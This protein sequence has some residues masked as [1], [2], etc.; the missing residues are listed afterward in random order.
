M[1]NGGKYKI[2]TVCGATGFPPALLRAWENRHGILRPERGAGGHRLYSDDDL[3]V[4]RRI[5]ELRESGRSIS[6][7]SR[8]GRA[9][10]LSDA[11][12][13]A[14]TPRASTQRAENEVIAGSQIERWKETIISSVKALD[15]MKI[16]RELDAAFSC[17]SPEAALQGLLEPLAIEIGNRW[18]HEEIS[19]A[20]EH[21]A[22]AVFVRRIQKILDAETVRDPM[23]PACICA[24]F[25]G[26]QHGIGILMVE[27]FLSRMGFR[28]T[29]LG[30]GLPFEDLE[31]CFDFLYAKAVFLS[32][33]RAALFR[34]HGPRLVE[35]ISRHPGIV[36]VIGGQGIPAHATDLE[37]VGARLW[38]E[39]RPIWD[40]RPE[41]LNLVTRSSR[42]RAATNP[43]SLP[44]GA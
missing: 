37:R 42:R 11:R 16:E 33:T 25:P 9:R 24:C 32:V 12:Q 43:A 3:L 2:S 8:L 7:I 35:L 44:D 29:Q 30:P 19:V 5:G 18:L 13:T 17:L 10:L 28:V 40:V 34:A 21:L 14:F 6:E 23:A 1:R 22:S 27:F 38:P 36:F 26:E 4:L 31:T 41:I 39:G 15:V 20:G